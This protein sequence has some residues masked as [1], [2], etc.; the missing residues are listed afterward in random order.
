MADWQT[1]KSPNGQ[2]LPRTLVRRNILFRG[3]PICQCPQRSSYAS[4]L[5]PFALFSPVVPELGLSLSSQSAA[6]RRVTPGAKART[7]NGTAMNHH[8]FTGV[9]V[10]SVSNVFRAFVSS[11]SRFVRDRL[12]ISKRSPAPIARGEHSPWCFATLPW[13]P[14]HFFDRP[15]SPVTRIRVF[16]ARVDQ[17][18]SL[19]SNLPGKLPLPG[20]FASIIEYLDL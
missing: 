15:A 1:V 12:R 19:S 17:F 6:S 14:V 11:I 3:P 4:L 8:R 7:R 9:N 13:T 2:D 18:L 10:R 5:L 16:S 20:F